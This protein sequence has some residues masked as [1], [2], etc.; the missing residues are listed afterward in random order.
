[1]SLDPSHCPNTSLH[2]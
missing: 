1:V 2:C